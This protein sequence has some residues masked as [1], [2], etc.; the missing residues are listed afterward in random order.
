MTPQKE[1]NNFDIKCGGKEID[2]MPEKKF[3]KL[4]VK[5]LENTGK[6]M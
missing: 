3:K 6:L 4:I 5:L 1:H 2:D